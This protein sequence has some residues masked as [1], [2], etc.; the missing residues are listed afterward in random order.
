VDLRRTPLQRGRRLSPRL[1]RGRHHPRQL[2]RLNLPRR[3]DMVLLIRLLLHQLPNLL[4][5]SQN[6][7]LLIRLPQHEFPKLNQSQS[8]SLR[9]NQSSKSEIG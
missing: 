9:Q 3:K 7:V 8:Q 5:H 1:Q 2:R 4:S 6:I